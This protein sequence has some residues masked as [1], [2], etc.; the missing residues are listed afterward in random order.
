MRVLV[1]GA[2]GVIGRTLVPRLVAAGHHVAG[3]TRTLANESVLRDLGAEP[4][5]CDV[6][7]RDRLIASTRDFRPDAVIHELTDL[8]DEAGDLA[9]KQADNAR[10]RVIGTRHLIDA[11]QAA[12]AT[13]FLAQSIAWQLPPGSGADAV[14]E[15]E[16]MV[17]DA[18][19]VVLR[20]G[21]LF[22]PGTYYPQTTGDG[23]PPHPRV[24]VETAAQ[25]TLE[26]LDDP[27]GVVVVTDPED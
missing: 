12:G 20:Y 27:S 16:A 10:I 2:S 6:F 11:A 17:L 15:L 26:A 18:N 25:R 19:G 4:I 13:R 22:G 8:P 23:L 7:D 5:V 21:R 3:V 1:A 24:H 9:S 14:A